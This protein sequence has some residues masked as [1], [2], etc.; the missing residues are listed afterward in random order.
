MFAQLG[1]IQFNLITYF[2]GIEETQKHN[3]VEHQTIE[4]K[5]KLQFM[6]DELDTLTIKLNFHSSFCVPETE[7]KKIKDAARL[8]EE[9]PFILGNGKYLGKYVIE[10]I[11]STTQQTDKTGNLISIEAEIKLREWFTEYL[12]VKKKSKKQTAKKKD[13]KKSSQK[14]LSQSKTPKQIVRQE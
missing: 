7:I 13:D 4:S 9:M 2:N 3:F 11:T 8:H 12:K 14:T 6:G 1:N 10:E 5:P